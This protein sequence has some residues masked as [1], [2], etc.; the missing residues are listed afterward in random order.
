MFGKVYKCADVHMADFD[1]LGDDEALVVGIV[2]STW[3][4]QI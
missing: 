2:M 1:H 4:G 3:A